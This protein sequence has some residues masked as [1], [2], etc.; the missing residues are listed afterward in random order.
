MRK[1]I[2][3]KLL[4]NLLEEVTKKYDSILSLKEEKLKDA[5]LMAIKDEL[6]GLYNRYYLK[7][8]LVKSIE[9]LKRNEGG[10]IFLIFIDLDNFKL[11]ND[12]YGHNKGDEVLKEI[13]QILSINFRKYDIIAR[14]GGD[15]FIIL[16]ESDN[17]PIERINTLRQKIEEIFR[18]FQLSFSYG[19][20]V[21]PD[22]IEDINMET[23]EII[24][25]LIEIADRRMYEE[26]MKREE[27][28]NFRIIKE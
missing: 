13:A 6:T 16:F 26:K 8:C 4:K 25:K 14:Y 1:E 18:E 9:R 3:I 20:S 17:E 2:K 15:E 11:I 28:N 21:F 19:V 5:Y 24:K 10:K 7:D 12:T 23:Q 22:D 27:G